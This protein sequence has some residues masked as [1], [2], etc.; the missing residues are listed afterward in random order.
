MN[1]YEVGT[2]QELSGVLH[3]HGWISRACD[4]YRANVCAH[5]FEDGRL[6]V[7]VRDSLD[8]PI[9]HCVTVPM[10]VKRFR[11]AS[12]PR[13]TFASL[14]CSQLTVLIPNRQRLAANAVQDRQE[15]RLVGV[16]EHDP[17]LSKHSS[18]S[19]PLGRCTPLSARARDCKGMHSLSCAKQALHS[20]SFRGGP[21]VACCVWATT[22]CVAGPCRGELGRLKDA[23]LLDAR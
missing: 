2:P 14:L 23:R 8:V 6:D 10:L 16:P 18:V 3:L 4:V 1:S 15:T 19:P 11:V 9:A 12:M 5:D 21:L 22:V 20:R 17:C 13:V 7:A